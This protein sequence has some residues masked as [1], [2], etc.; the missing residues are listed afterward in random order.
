MKQFEIIECRSSQSSNFQYE[1]NVFLL[2]Y[3][4]SIGKYVGI[5]NIDLL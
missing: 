3:Q 1:R 5:V 2:P 4:A